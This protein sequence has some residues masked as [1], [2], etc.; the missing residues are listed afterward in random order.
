MTLQSSFFPTTRSGFAIMLVL[1]ISAILLL[2]GL[3]TYFFISQENVSLQIIT[4]S[5]IAHFLA[6]SGIAYSVRSIRESLASAGGENGSA[7]EIRK[8]LEKPENLPD[9]SLM[10][11]LKDTWNADL[12]KFATE[13]DPTASIK[14]EVWFRKFRPT[15]TNKA[16]WVD[17]GAKFGY[18]S[19]ESIGE[20]RGSRRKIQVYRPVKVG[21]CLPPVYCRFTLH[22]KDAGRGEPDRFNLLLNDYDGINVDPRPV[23]VYNHDL[24][25]SRLEAKPL[26]QIL[27]EE[28]DEKIFEKRGSIFLGKTPINLHLTS[29]PGKYGEIFH[30]YEVSNSNKFKAVRFKKT[31]E[32]LPSIFGS[33]FSWYWDRP[34][35]QPGQ[36]VRTVSYLFDYS[37]ILAGFHDKSGTSQTDAMFLGNILSLEKPKY[38]SK[39]SILHLFGE[40]EQGKQ[41]RTM[42]Y[43][44]VNLIFPRY[45]Y[46]DI[47]PQE[48]DVLKMFSEVKDPPPTFLLPALTQSEFE[49]GSRILEDLK[50]RRFGAPLLPFNRFFQNYDQYKL[51]MSSVVEVPYNTSYNSIQNILTPE[52]VLTY[53]PTR[54][55]IKP[56]LSENI[57]IDRNG[58]VIYEGSI[59]PGAFLDVVRARVQQEFSDVDSFWKNCFDK[60]SNSL[61]LNRI[62]RIVNPRKDTFVIPPGTSNSSLQL[63]DGGMI[64]L[65][66]GNVLIKGVETKKTG[67]ILTLIAPEATNVSINSDRPCEMF[68]VAPKADLSAPGKLDFSGSLAVNFLDIRGNCSGGEIK[69]RESA[70]PVFNGYF[71][72]YKSWIESTDENWFE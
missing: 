14:V 57:K 32:Q 27:S 52:A 30:I 64:I 44:N 46:S 36:P 23:I 4:N 65:E 20:Y 11:Y 8:L 31:K 41:S 25:D 39:S 10:P 35:L 5:E 56:E 19:V 67:Q 42:V 71:N 1:A 6:E 26:A 37:F 54:E 66:N 63:L 15:E 61:K 69:Y 12:G 22:V 70:N 38:G 29:G 72:Y 2:M 7:G 62:V 55:L 16:A 33:P 60:N 49:T 9:T 40:A 28:K 18:L 45:S 17:P 21:N 34:D 58:Q 59:N 53:P 48:S 43:G 3:T 13:M 50:K 24:P 47:T 51:C 68:L